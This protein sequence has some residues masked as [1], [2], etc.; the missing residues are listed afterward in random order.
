MSVLEK[1]K[2]LPTMIDQLISGLAYLHHAGWTHNDI[3]DSTVCINVDQFSRN[4]RVLVRNLKKTTKLRFRNDGGAVTV[5]FYPRLYLI[6]SPQWTTGERVDPRA[7]DM[8]NVGTLLY[9]LLFVD[10]PIGNLPRI[11]SISRIGLSGLSSLPW[12]KC[13]YVSS[14]ETNPKTLIYPKLAS[15]DSFAR[16]LMH[17]EDYLSIGSKFM[18]GYRML[19]GVN[20]QNFK[21]MS[22]LWVSKIVLAWM[23]K[24]PLNI[25][26][27]ESHERYIVNFFYS[28]NLILLPEAYDTYKEKIL[29]LLYMLK[30][31]LNPNVNSRPTSAIYARQM[32]MHTRFKTNVDNIIE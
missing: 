23:S 3:G 18:P 15:L 21:P 16:L 24:T 26:A 4:A 29:P 19:T 13:Y 27:E 12:Q 30:D 6:D 31:L 2:T 1:V 14:G 10:N 8:W 11:G 25:L 7:N 32:M 5:K 28:C 22:A 17:E 20:M 9:G